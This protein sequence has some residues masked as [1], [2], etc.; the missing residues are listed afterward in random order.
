VLSDAEVSCELA[1][2]AAEY[3]GQL[4][5]GGLDGSDLPP[6]VNF[7]EGPRFGQ[8]DGTGVIVLDD[9]R[10]AVISV[11]VAPDGA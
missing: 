3:L 6:S 11:A 7:G 1:V 10:M 4:M 9:G 8:L 5:L 2:S